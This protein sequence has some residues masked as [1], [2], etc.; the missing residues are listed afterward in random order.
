M[1]NVHIPGIVTELPG[2]KS[3]KLIDNDEKDNRSSR[4]RN[5]SG[6]ALE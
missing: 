6:S 4:M 5:T 3:R 2:P 1:A